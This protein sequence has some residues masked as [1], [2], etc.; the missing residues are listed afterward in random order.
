MSEDD[1]R[2]AVELLIEK[3]KK[4]K[5]LDPQYFFIKRQKKDRYISGRHPFSG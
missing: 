3:L 1:R 4:S 2:T 5:I